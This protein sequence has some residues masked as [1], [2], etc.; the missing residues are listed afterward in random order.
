MGVSLHVE[1]MAVLMRESEDQVTTS[2]ARD[3][4]FKTS[5]QRRLSVSRS[6]AK[7]RQTRKVSRVSMSDQ[8]MLQRQRL[9]RALIWSRDQDPGFAVTDFTPIPLDPQFAKKSG[10]RD[11]RPAAQT[12]EEREMRRREQNN[13]AQQKKAARDAHAL[14]NLELELHHIIEQK[15]SCYA[16]LASSDPS[17]GSKLTEE[18]WDQHMDLAISMDAVCELDDMAFDDVDIMTD[19][20]LDDASEAASRLISLS[21]PEITNLT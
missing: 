6:L 1:Q 4:R 5:Y 10:K 19:V 17:F 13:V 16:H 12:Q 9:E 8:L 18:D 21:V 15:K 2:D 14:L 20:T 11:K 7:L 3:S